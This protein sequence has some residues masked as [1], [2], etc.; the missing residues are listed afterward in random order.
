VCKH[1]D[2]LARSEIAPKEEHTPNLA[3]HNHAS[4]VIDSA[5]AGRSPLKPYHDHLPK[6]VLKLSRVQAG[7]S[8]P[9]DPRDCGLTFLGDCRDI[10]Q[11]STSDNGSQ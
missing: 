2:L 11:Q 9:G 10:D 6:H 1:T 7:L 5:L 3:S 8:R 4:C